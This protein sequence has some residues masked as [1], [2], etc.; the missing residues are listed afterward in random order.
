MKDIIKKIFK[1][2]FPSVHGVFL[3]FNIAS[4]HVTVSPKTST[5]GHGKPI[6]LKFLVE[7]D[8]SITKITLKAPAG[9]EIMSYQ[10]VPGWNFK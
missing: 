5:T 2:L 9:I 8:V 10:P 3:F 4:A 6:R 7:K 1:V